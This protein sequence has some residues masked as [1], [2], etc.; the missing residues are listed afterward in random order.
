[1]HQGPNMWI[2]NRFPWWSLGIQQCVC[3]D[4]KENGDDTNPTPIYP[5]KYT[6]VDNLEYIGREIVGVEYL[7]DPAH[8]TELTEMELDHWAYGPHHAW[9]LPE[10]GE[11]R[12]M[13]QPFNG[14]QVYPPPSTMPGEVDPSQFA[15]IPPAKCLPGGATFRTGCGDDGFPIK[16]KKTSGN[17]K[18]SVKPK[19]HMRA[20]TKVPRHDYKGMDFT[21]MSKVLNYWLNE[22]YSTVPCDMWK[23]EELQQL[24][25]LF[26]IA[27]ESQFDEIYQQTSDNRRLRHHLLNVSLTFSAS[28]FSSAPL[29][30]MN[31]ILL[32]TIMQT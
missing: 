30:Q 2:V 18:N 11:I 3:V 28:A 4:I 1:M 14:L 27:K 20:K 8:P 9:T 7:K 29:S 17:K 25:A 26:Y 31:Y 19:D 32:H 22:S 16:D 10:S 21:D 12:R 15:T 23:V 24:Q 5:I 6:W 13:W